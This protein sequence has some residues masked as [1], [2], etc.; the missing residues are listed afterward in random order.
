METLAAA[1]QLAKNGKV[2]PKATPADAGAALV[3][4]PDGEWQVGMATGCVISY[5]GNKLNFTAAE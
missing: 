4:G 2:L 3:V 5:S 1:L